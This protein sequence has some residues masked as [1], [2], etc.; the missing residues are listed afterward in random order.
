[1]YTISKWMQT[2]FTN[3]AFRVKGVDLRMDT[4]KDV[5]FMRDWSHRTTCS[6]YA[7]YVKLNTH[8]NRK[9]LDDHLWSI[10]FDKKIKIF[11]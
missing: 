5:Y 1:M 7:N 4:Q 6:N 10:H 3:D 11:K 2:C 8:H 9:D